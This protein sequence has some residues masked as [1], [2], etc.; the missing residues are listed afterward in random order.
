ML[1]K[2]D[3]VKF[4][5][6]PWFLKKSTKNPLALCPIQAFDTAKLLIK[7]FFQRKSTKSPS[8]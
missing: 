8:D 3:A 7:T 5:K 4:L 2:L 1:S 6:N